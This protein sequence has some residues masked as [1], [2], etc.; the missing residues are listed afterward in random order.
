M[1][2]SR[3]DRCPKC[4]GYVMLQRDRYGLYEECLQC[5]YVHDLLT[6]AEAEQRQAEE[7]KSEVFSTLQSQMV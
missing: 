1:E 3:L 4:K 6:V 2:I 5:G 7:E